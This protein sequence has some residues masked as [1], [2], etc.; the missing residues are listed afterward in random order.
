[1]SDSSRIDRR[2][3]LGSILGAATVAG[4]KGVGAAS[5][6]EAPRAPTGVHVLGGFYGGKRLLQ[7]TDFEYLGGFILPQRTQGLDTRFSRGLTH[8]YVG[9]DLRFFSAAHKDAPIA[10]SRAGRRAVRVRIPRPQRSM[11]SLPTAPIIRHWG[12]IYQGKMAIGPSFEARRGLVETSRGL[13][14][15]EEGG[16]STG[17]TVAAAVMTGIAALPRPRRL[18]PAS[19]IRQ[20]ALLARLPHGGLAPATY[21]CVMR[22]CVPIRNGLRK[23]IPEAVE[24][25]RALAATFR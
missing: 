1:M 18:E 14:W 10:E 13:W 11:G 20:M 17:R 7:P 6:Q 16:R 12:D 2:A 19:S 8:R 3:F 24:S 22:G 25:R 5:I 21:K 23:R 9:A 4:V 15:D